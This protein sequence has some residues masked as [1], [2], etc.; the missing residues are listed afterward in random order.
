MSRKPSPKEHAALV[1]I[2]EAAVVLE[3]EYYFAE[4]AEWVEM[5]EGLSAWR[6]KG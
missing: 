1:R 5:R 4:S 2:A 3:S 6:G